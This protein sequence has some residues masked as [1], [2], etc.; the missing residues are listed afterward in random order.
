MCYVHI[1]GHNTYFVN[2]LTLLEFE[3]VNITFG[4]LKE[5]IFSFN[6]RWGVFLKLHEFWIYKNGEDG[7]CDNAVLV[8]MY[9]IKHFDK[10][11]EIRE[12]NDYIIS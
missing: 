3:F 8:Y 6:L 7:M 1:A 4:K 5:Y 11:I 10:Y 2:L 12:Y 9:I